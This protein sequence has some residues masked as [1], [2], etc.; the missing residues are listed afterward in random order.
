[1]TWLPHDFVDATA[2]T[3]AETMLLL[4][5]LWWCVCVCFVGR[6]LRFNHTGF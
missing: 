5:T 4:A 1:M 6:F 2:A 3:D